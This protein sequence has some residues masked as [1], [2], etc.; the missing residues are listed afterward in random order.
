ME[1]TGERL[2]PEKPEL[3]ELYQHHILRYVFSKPYARGKIVLDAACGSGYGSHY[4]AR[5]GALKVIGVDIAED[6][7]A[8]AAMTYEMENVEFRVMDVAAMS[9]KDESFDLVCSFETIEHIPDH[10][11]FLFEARRV[12]KPGGK[13]VISSPNVE[14]YSADTGDGSNPFHITEFS[15]T[16]FESLLK[17][18]FSEVNMFFQKPEAPISGDNLDYEV[19]LCMLELLLVRLQEMRYEP[20][21]GLSD[22]VIG[23]QVRAMRRTVN[24]SESRWPGIMRK[25]KMFLGGRKDVRAVAAVVESLVQSTKHVEQLTREREHRLWITAQQLIEQL[26]RYG[27]FNLIAERES[28]RAD[29]MGT[30]TFPRRQTLHENDPGDALYF[31]AVATKDEA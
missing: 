23:E 11:A 15:K 25:A 4:L 21:Q 14:Q 3:A 30:V 10:E 13:L 1:F 19:N 20:V 7:V 2:V 29:D 17:K 6:A 22:E 12:L 26:L 28:R 24:L 5:N 31:V 18:H 8:H 16:E 9:F 27:D